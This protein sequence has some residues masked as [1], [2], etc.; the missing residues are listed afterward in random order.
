MAKLSKAVKVFQII[1][2]LASLSLATIDQIIELIK[3]DKTYL[4]A[5]SDKR[6]VVAFKLFE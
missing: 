2:I 3:N 5:S 6:N 1:S 4:K